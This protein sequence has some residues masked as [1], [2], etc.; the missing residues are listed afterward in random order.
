MKVF[1][2]ADS[3]YDITPKVAEAV[4]S[5]RQQAEQFIAEH[6]RLHIGQDWEIQEFE[7]DAPTPIHREGE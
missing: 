7:I 1:V 3:C 6:E 5:S 2:A 4:F